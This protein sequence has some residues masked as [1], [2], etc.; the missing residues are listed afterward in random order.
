PSFT[1]NVPTTATSEQEYSYNI[2][3]ADSDGDG[4]VI[5]APTLPE[6]LTLTDN[7]DGTATL[8]GTPTNSDTGLNEVDLVVSDGTDTA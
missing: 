3:T 1:S 8:S 5:T 2:T 4:L 6:W 7:G